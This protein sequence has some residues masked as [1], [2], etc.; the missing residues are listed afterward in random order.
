MR[1]LAHINA[2]C[3][4]YECATWQT[5]VRCACC[6]FQTEG[7]AFLSFFP[8]FFVYFVLNCRCS[9]R[10]RWMMR[11]YTRDALARMLH[12]T[13]MNES[14]HSHQH[15]T[16]HRCMC[17]AAHLNVSCRTPECA[18]L[19]TWMRHVAHTHAPRC[20]HECAILHAWMRHFA[21]MHMYS[22]SHRCM[23]HARHIL[24]SCHIGRVLVCVCTSGTKIDTHLHSGLCVN[25]RNKDS[26]WI[27]IVLMK[28]W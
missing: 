6:A 17:H 18:R 28:D 25:V 2:S 9:L 26:Y 21:Y 13:Y 23:R 22:M 1:H 12:V 7:H 4:A 10:E 20:T 19:P 16:L 11:S 14:W 27:K 5:Y 15:V 8:L 24:N 3:H